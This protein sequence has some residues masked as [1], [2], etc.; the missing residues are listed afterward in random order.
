MI[1]HLPINNIAIIMVSY[2]TK[3][4]SMTSYIQIHLFRI[5]SL[6]QLHKIVSAVFSIILFCGLTM[7]TLNAYSLS[8]PILDA[9]NDDLMVINTLST[10]IFDND[11]SEVH[12][13]SLEYIIIDEMLIEPTDGVVE[14]I[15]DFGLLQIRSNGDTTITKTDEEFYGIIGPITYSATNGTVSGTANINIDFRISP[16]LAPDT[17]TAPYGGFVEGNIFSN[18][19]SQPETSLQF[20][21]FYDSQTQIHLN[22]VE[23]PNTLDLGFATF[24]VQQNGDF[25]LTA[26]EGQTGSTSR[27]R[28]SASDGFLS[29]FAI[30]YISVEQQIT[31]LNNDEYYSLSSN[32]IF[33]NVFSNDILS[34]VIT[35]DSVMLYSRVIEFDEVIETEG[36]SFQIDAEGNL[37]F[38]IAPG[39]HGVIDGFQYF[40]TF[41]D[42]QYSASISFFIGR[43]NNSAPVVNSERVTVD[44]GSTTIIEL[45]DNDYDPDDI[46]YIYVSGLRIGDQEYEFGELNLNDEIRPLCAGCDAL[47]GIQADTQ[48]GSFQ[49]NRSGT[50]IFVANTSFVGHLPDI[51]YT[52]T[53]DMASTSGIIQIQIL[54]ESDDT[55]SI[56]EA[57]DD[58]ITI[59]PVMLYESYVYI[60]NGLL[61]NDINLSDTNITITS[62]MYN[63][64]IIST[65]GG[66]AIFWINEYALI[67]ITSHGVI[68]LQSELEL[69]QTIE[70]EYTISN[71]THSDRA[72]AQLILRPRQMNDG[73][74]TYTNDSFVINQGS[75]VNSNIFDN[76]TLNSPYTDTVIAVGHVINIEESEDFEASNYFEFFYEHRDG[77]YTYHNDEGVYEI[78]YN[79]VFKFTPHPDFVGVTRPLY[80]LT[81]EMYTFNILPL[82][83]EN[84][85]YFDWFDY[86]HLFTTIQV[87][88]NPVSNQNN[89]P[90]T[91]PQTPVPPQNPTTSSN[92][93]TQDSDSDGIRDSIENAGPNNGDGNNDG[94][95]DSLQANVATVLTPNGYVTI[96]VRGDLAGCN[97]INNAKAVD[98]TQLPPSG[99]TLPN[100]LVS[101]SSPCAGTLEVTQFWHGANPNTTYELTKYGPTIPGNMSTVA[102]YPFNARFSLTSINGNNVVTVNYTL[103]DGQLG[104]DTGVDGTIVDPVGLSIAGSHTRRLVATGGSSNQHSVYLFSLLSLLGYVIYS[105]MFISGY[106]KKITN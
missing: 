74:N 89:T 36:G 78:S 96:Q 6:I 14:H 93:P 71:G 80:I 56:V 62:I 21:H 46:D 9:Q 3:T 27:Y 52:V 23:Y 84:I 69:E 28:Y 33:E 30:L 11:L 76:D 12:S 92:N 1:R 10:N 38:V 68:T 45:L 53:D 73:I 77:S 47:I 44:S 85:E 79:G 15:F 67:S 25:R 86:L 106:Q 72:T 2:Q 7:T 104:D 90:T 87:T 5:S 64:E 100:G 17:I 34:D 40:A 18:D 57:H 35:L 98:P 81:S 83:F 8:A 43:Y 4:N 54:G 58:E 49:L 65:Y 99:I 51:S 50:F 16:R 105:T 95:K 63:E 48:W 55:Q 32:N 91:T 22:T 39:Y 94:I 70:F 24:T 41:N 13:L 75:S 97:I 102:F 42:I 101:F 19:S 59:S 61:T 26:A 82:I 29:T 66:S 20:T 31:T 60:A 88:V 37:S 103:R